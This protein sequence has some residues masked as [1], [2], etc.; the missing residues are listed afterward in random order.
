MEEPSASIWHGTSPFALRA[1][2]APAAVS[3]SPFLRIEPAPAATQPVETAIP[4]PVTTAT[5]SA[6]ETPAADAPV[7]LPV[8]SKTVYTSAVAVSGMFERPEAAA[9][10]ATDVPAAAVLAESAPMRASVVAVSRTFERHA[11]TDVAAS[12]AFAPLAAAAAAASPVSKPVPSVDTPAVAVAA[13][14]VPDLPAA[15][16][17]V[18]TGNGDLS[19]PAPE[20]PA[21]ARRLSTV[22]E[23]AAAAVAEAP[24]SPARE[25]TPPEG[26]PTDAKTE[27]DAEAEA[28]VGA[29]SQFD[30][31]FN[32]FKDLISSA[33]LAVAKI[34]EA[35]RRSRALDPL[36]EGGY[37]GI[38]ERAG[39][40][41]FPARDGDGGVSGGDLGVGP[42]P[43]YG[44]PVAGLGAGPPPFY[45][46]PV[47]GSG[48]GADSSLVGDEDLELDWE[49]GESAEASRQ[50]LYLCMEAMVRHLPI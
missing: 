8:K 31:S 16:A 44:L 32:P 27:A 2:P 39:A 12:A 47:A 19:E 4:L 43:F 10:P 29:S 36:P 40:E 17:A 37:S 45:G 6:F 30:D 15:A 41:E 48:V 14:Q 46:L 11:A 5:L 33:Y 23:V 38:G 24:P 7:V 3:P 20:R 50:K 22:S 1:H 9:V 25:D 49:E 42:P 35:E 18:A 21:P 26:V 13:P 34:A 28:D